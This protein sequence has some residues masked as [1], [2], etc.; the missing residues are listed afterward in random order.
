MKF[1]VAFLSRKHSLK[2]IEVASQHA[3]A[4][5][6]ELSILKVIPDPHKVGTVAE[7]IATERPLDKAHE[8]VETIAAE[9]QNNGI[10]A[11]GIVR[12][13][14]VAKVIVNA[15]VEDKADLLFIGTISS[16]PGRMFLMHKDP[17]VHYVIDHC[18]VSVCLIRQEY[19]WLSRHTSRPCAQHSVNTTIIVRTS[20]TLPG[21]VLQGL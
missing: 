21:P 3:R 19:A 15:A 17:I 12:V 16:T 2:T 4:L 20:A 9:L 8:Q 7:L 6:A 14:E 13:D 5:N 11:K 10:N 18:P 1:M